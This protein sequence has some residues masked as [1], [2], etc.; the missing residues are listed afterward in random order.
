MKFEAIARLATGTGIAYCSSVTAGAL[1]IPA[2]S[3]IRTISLVTGEG[4]NYDQTKGNAASSFS[5]KGAD[6]APYVEA[7]TSSAAG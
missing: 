2:E 6:P 1:V 7:V 4:T 3:H 5:F